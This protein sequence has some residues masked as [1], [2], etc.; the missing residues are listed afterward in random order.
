M[1]EYIEKKY[2]IFYLNLSRAINES[3]IRYWCESVKSLK[4]Y[5]EKLTGNEINEEKLKEI[6]KQEAQIREKLVALRLGA[7]RKA[8]TPLKASDMLQLLSL[9]QCLGQQEYLNLLEEISSDYGCS[10]PEKEDSEKPIF[11][12]LGP[13]FMEESPKVLSDEIVTGSDILKHIEKSD[14]KTIEDPW[15]E[16]LTQDSYE[17]PDGKSALE[18]VGENS[19]LRPKHPCLAPNAAK[20][21]ENQALAKKFGVKGVIYFNYKGCR[22]SLMESRLNEYMFDAEGIPYLHLQVSGKI[23]DVD[24][25]HVATESFIMAN[26]K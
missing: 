11:Y 15:S 21:D 19:Y 16:I 12:L 24:N 25:I 22:V 10:I 14:I 1:W 6:V 26:C 2:P 8:E 3:S 5:L 23:G 13:L 17:V 4:K 9:R 20:I 18:W 7:L